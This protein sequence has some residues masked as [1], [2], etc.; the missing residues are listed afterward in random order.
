VK[1][2]HS[3]DRKTRSADQKLG[4]SGWICRESDQEIQCDRGRYS[5]WSIIEERFAVAVEVIADELTV[6][7]GKTSYSG[8]N[9]FAT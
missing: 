1:H 8:N 2:R 4:L 5:G 6:T 3:A 7:L 9:L